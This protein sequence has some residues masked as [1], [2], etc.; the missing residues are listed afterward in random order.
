MAKLLI[1]PPKIN[2]NSLKGSFW[3][4]LGMI[5]LATTISLFFAIV[6]TH[7]LE[8]R[9]RAKDRRLSAMMVMSNIEKF[10][11]NLEEIAVHIAPADS[12]VDWLLSKPV[13]ELEL[14]PEEVLDG[15]ITQASDLLF[16]TY[17][18]TT[19]SIF[20]SNIETWKN[21]G[22]V[23]FIDK[24]GQCFS[25]MNMVEERWNGW[26]TGVEESIRDIKDHPDNYEGST[27]PINTSGE[28]SGTKRFSGCCLMGSI[29]CSVLHETRTRRAI[30]IA[31]INGIPYL[32]FLC[33]VLWCQTVIPN[34]APILP[35]TTA[36][37]NKTDSGTRHL[38]RCALN[39]S[40]PYKKKV[41]TLMAA[42]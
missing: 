33:R 7:L 16:L 34:Q 6:T 17:D 1:R 18:K 36:S 41:I 39:L 15:L 29:V 13:E 27:V 3:K 10:S 25:A 19:E 28:C 12:A 35:P 42:R 40:I 32:N 14:L 4:Q 24:V 30:C 26:V 37:P 2:V 11:R 31:S 21:M 9:H 22:N 38:A 8:K 23:Q 5:V 20:S